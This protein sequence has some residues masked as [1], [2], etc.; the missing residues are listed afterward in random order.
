MI[1]HRK[2][3]YTSNHKSLAC[4][5]CHSTEYHEFPHPLEPRMEEHLTCIDCH[6][7]DENM[8][9]YHFEKI[10]EAYD[11]STHAQIPGFSC[12]QCH[13]PHTYKINIRTTENLKMAIAYDNAICLSCHADAD[14]FKLLTRRKEINIIQKHEWLPNQSMHFSSVRCIECHT[15]VNDTVLVAHKV[16]PASQA[17]RK[18]TECHSKN[19]MLMS[20]L[21][22][23]QAKTK[24]SET[25][26]LNTS[27]MKDAFV[28]S[29][30]R[31]YYLNL[32]SLILFGLAVAGIITHTILRII[33]KQK[34]S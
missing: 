32:I 13:N 24:R 11:S 14:R 5:D 25:G 12:W 3:Y 19:S 26:F 4:T 30:N 29:A 21:F 10:Q 18:C 6:G 17:I 28:I 1:I 8:A 31:N 33:L 2:D 23:F 20:T 15:E 16:L 22:K 7:G 27:I 34:K 9:K